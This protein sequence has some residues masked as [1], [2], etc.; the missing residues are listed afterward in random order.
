MKVFSTLQFEMEKILGTKQCGS[1]NGLQLYNTALKRQKLSHEK[2]KCEEGVY[3]G[4]VNENGKMKTMMTF[5][6]TLSMY[7]AMKK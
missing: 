7:N 4:E 2:R 6:D 1:S 3:N 5:D